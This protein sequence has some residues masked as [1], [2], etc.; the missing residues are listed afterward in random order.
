MGSCIELACYF[1]QKGQLYCHA[2]FSFV[3]VEGVVE[4]VPFAFVQTL[5]ILHILSG[6][7]RINNP[8]EK[9]KHVKIPGHSHQ[10]H[11]EIAQSN[12]KMEAKFLHEQSAVEPF[13]SFHE[14]S[15]LQN[16][17]KGLKWIQGKA[18]NK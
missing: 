11:R 13:H 12:R 2:R 1:Q 17:R 16:R 3:G 8:N 4:V 10:I 5:K 15:H 7:S 14:Q 9:V 18:L 6:N